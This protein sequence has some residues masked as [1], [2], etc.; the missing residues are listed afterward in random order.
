M[1]VMFM[2]TKTQKV[3]IILT[4][5][6]PVIIKQGKSWASSHIRRDG[7]SILTVVYKHL[8]FGNVT[9][10]DCLLKSVSKTKILFER[11]LQIARL[12]RCRAIKA[13]GY[14]DSS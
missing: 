1:I 10:L 11:I 8:F 5:R 12:K 7:V 13:R 3:V 14:L 2:E 4:S 9:K 6:L